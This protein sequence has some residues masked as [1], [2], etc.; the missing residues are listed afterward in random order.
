MYVYGVGDPKTTSDRC[1]TTKICPTVQNRV[2]FRDVNGVAIY[3]LNGNAGTV[4]NVEQGLKDALSSFV[5]DAQALVFSPSGLALERILWMGAYNCRCISGKDKLSG[6]AFGR[7][8]DIGGWALRGGGT[9]PLQ[10]FIYERLVK[11]GAWDPLFR[12]GA[13]L[14]L[15]F[16]QVLY[17]VH[18]GHHDHFHAEIGTPAPAAYWRFIDMA[19]SRML[20]ESLISLGWRRSEGGYAPPSSGKQALMNSRVAAL[21]EYAKRLPSW[22]TDLFNRRF[23]RSPQQEPGDLSKLL[24]LTLAR[25]GFRPAPQLSPGA[26]TSFPTP[27]FRPAPSQ[28]PSQSEPGSAILAPPKILADAVKSGALTMVAAS[29]ILAGERDVNRLTNLI[30]YSRHPNLPVG[31]KIQ[32][33]EQ[34]LAREWLEIRDKLVIPVLRRFQPTAINTPKPTAAAPARPVSPAKLNVFRG[35]LPFLNRDRG[36]IPLEFL[37]GWI[38]VE[39]GGN[40]G[41]VT[42][43]LNE[44]GYFQIHPDESKTLRLDH[45]RL[46]RDPEYSI[47]SGI[48]LVRH[49]AQRAQQLGFT[50]GTD[51]FW[52]VVKLLHWLPH[53]VQKI[54]ENM[55]KHGVDP[56]ALSWDEFRSHVTRYRPEICQS[57]K[58]CRGGWD[59]LVGIA[60]VDKVFDRGGRLAAEL[61]S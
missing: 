12:V 59:P 34:G 36:D 18:D 14:H 44:R 16:Q 45:E 5:R 25:G 60:N 58:S 17:W 49:R 47:N 57:M 37:L 19:L 9:G 42:R 48:R 38:D 50:Y 29:S 10:N 43:S 21:Q 6:H 7:A 33:R 32:P 28:L 40:I 53:G 3:S 51:L 22:A 54:L 4:S 30:F 20:G 31:Y 46:T 13:C 52:H 61:S 2:E 56:N 41:V 26:A 39:S 23:G 24:L 55:R 15:N 1:K 11:E 27:P 8:I 35:L